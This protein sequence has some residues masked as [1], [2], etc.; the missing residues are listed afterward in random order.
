[1]GYGVK[2][3]GIVSSLHM[4]VNKNSARIIDVQQDFDDFFAGEQT[5]IGNL[6]D[7]MQVDIRTLK[8]MIQANGHPVNFTV[9]SSTVSVADNPATG[10]GIHP[11]TVPQEGPHTATGALRPDDANKTPWVPTTNRFHM[12]DGYR[13][14]FC[15]LSFPSGNRFPHKNLA[16]GRVRLD[17]SSPNESVEGAFGGVPLD[18]SNT[19]TPSCM[20][21]HIESPRPSNKERFAHA[22]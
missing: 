4:D 10:V 12:A 9:A 11:P 22:C 1:M 14:G 3:D 5:S 16:T 17:D 2:N 13:P 18:A 21:G 8:T 20:G 6:C 7:K 15:S 19:P